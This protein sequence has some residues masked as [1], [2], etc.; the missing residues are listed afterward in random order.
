MAHQ[1]HPDKTGGDDSKFK[2]IN[3]AYQVLSDK[4]KRSQYDQFGSGFENMGGYGGAG[5]QG[6][7]GFEGFN[8]QGFAQDFDLGDI[9]GE[10]FGGGS[11]R[12]SSSGSSRTK[13]RKGSDIEISL[14]IDFM[15]AVF[16]INKEITLKRIEKC[17]HC[18]GAGNEP[19]TKVNT[20]STCNGRG[21]VDRLVNSFF[22]QMRTQITCESCGGEGKTFEK[23][24]T[25]CN[26]DGIIASNHDVKINIP[27]GIDN[28]QTLRLTDEGNA[29]SN[30]GKNGDLYINVKIKAH[31]FFK[32]EGYNILT[33]IE[34]SFPEAALGCT[35]DVKTVNGE[36][37]LKIPAGIQSGTIIKLD[38]QGVKK[39]QSKGTGDHLITVKVTTPK[40]LSAKE[41][42]IYEDL[43]K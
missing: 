10:F 41:K 17:K 35:T 36:F 32:R 14:E 37:S 7:G 31:N 33:N 4:N 28:N 16:G 30:N 8:G 40:H 21:S 19:G 38:N 24:C 3:E 34:I 39:L 12:S 15:D 42:K 22:G 2:E 23:K 9:F 27:A 26:G 5:G 13:P 1:H 11:R 29:G 18:D 25:S 43:L 20:C 6:F